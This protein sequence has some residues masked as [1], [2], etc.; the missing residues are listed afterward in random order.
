MWVCQPLH[1]TRSRHC[2]NGICFGKRVFNRLIMKETNAKLRSL[3]QKNFPKCTVELYSECSY[4]GIK[5]VYDKD[6]PQVKLEKSYK[7]MKLKNCQN[8]VIQLFSYRSFIGTRKDFTF[9]VSCSTFYDLFD[10]TTSLKI[11][12]LSTSSCFFLG[13]SE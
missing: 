1:C 13:N 8:S 6:T 5:H 2:Q 3:S 7:S 12:T 10:Q 4:R 9:D 11:G